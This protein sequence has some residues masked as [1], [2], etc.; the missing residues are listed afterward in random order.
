M[1]PKSERIT[2]TAVY[3]PDEKGWVNARVLEIP[4][5]N[6]CA[7]TIEEARELL[8]DAARE[9]ILSYADDEREG[10]KGARYERLEVALR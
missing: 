3:E 10:E 7:R 9:L 4:G 1:V 8:A 5:V 2:L 6:T